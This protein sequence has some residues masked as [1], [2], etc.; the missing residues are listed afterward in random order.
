MMLIGIPKEIKPFEYRV[1]L[2]P[3]QVKELVLKKYCDVMVETKAG[4]ASGFS[5]EMYSECG[6]KIVNAE[7][8]YSK[9]N[10]IVKVK[11]PEQSEIALMNDK[12][13]VF[14]F[15]HFASNSYIKEA[16]GNRA[17][18]FEEVV[19]ENRLPILEPMSQVAGRLAVLEGM[20]YLIETKGMLVTGLP[21][22]RAAKVFIIG[23][24]IV[25][26]N[27]A[28]IASG[29]GMDVVIA[30]ID[31]Q[32][33]SNIE[34]NFPANVR[35]VYSN[36]SNLIKNICD[37]DL[38]IGAVLSPGYATPKIIKRDHISLMQPGSVFVDVSIDQGGCSETSRPTTHTDPVY[39]DCNVLHYCVTNMPG[40]V[41]KTS[42]KALSYEV[43]PYV[44]DLLRGEF[45]TL[46][47]HKA[48]LKM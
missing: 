16:L 31:A 39:Y 34:A 28:R 23:A 6:A 27:A 12:A 32:K 3:D 41:P 26:Q 40:I 38:L 5:D 24:G 17:V 21:T 2:M 42:T 30:D 14:S 10:L 48:D 7:D 29:L 44:V 25:G 13:C 46:L 1:A 15:M 43:F 22:V 47:K 36:E 37:C 20:A 9:C 19:K 35:P 4:E 45:L 11:E 18:A 33:L 8:I